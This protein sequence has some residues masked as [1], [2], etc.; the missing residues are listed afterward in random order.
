M[1]NQY[2]YKINKLDVWDET[3]PHIHHEAALSYELAEICEVPLEPFD[4]YNY[5]DGLEEPIKWRN[6]IKDCIEVSQMF[7]GNYFEIECES[8]EENA[9]YRICCFGGNCIQSSPTIMYPEIKIDDF[10]NLQVDLLTSDD[11]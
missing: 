5:G 3:R 4:L 6:D 7:P 8:E 1:S 10:I 11:N 9:T 2:Y